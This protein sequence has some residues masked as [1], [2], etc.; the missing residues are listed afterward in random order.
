MLLATL[1]NYQLCGAENQLDIVIDEMQ[2]QNVSDGSPIYKI[3]KEGRKYHIA[4]IGATQSFYQKHDP[5]G[6]V[7]NHAETMIF[8]KPKT[9]SEKDAANVLG[10]TQKEMR[11]FRMMDRG[12]CFVS[13]KFYN[14][15]EGCNRPAVLYGKVFSAI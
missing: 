11:K 2:T 9:D 10:L 8:L 1:Y 15:A 6:K 12:D 3:L 7:M 13:G 5:V 14:K 4:F